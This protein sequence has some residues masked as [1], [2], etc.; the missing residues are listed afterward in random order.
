VWYALPGENN[1]QGFCV[2]LQKLKLNDSLE[3]TF[4]FSNLA[5]YH[6]WIDVAVICDLMNPAQSAAIIDRNKFS[7]LSSRGIQFQMLPMQVVY[8]LKFS[9]L[10]NEYPVAPKQKTDYVF[11]FS[12]EN[13][14]S[15]QEAMN[16]LLTD[17]V[18]FLYH[19]DLIADTL[20]KIV[21]DDSKIKKRP[22]S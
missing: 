12:S 16:L 9:T 7:I 6:Q 4:L 20:F 22:K 5:Y 11:N 15:K 13:K 21:E 1:L 14:Y 10:P 2:G 19:H 17:T 8:D 3:I 18:Y